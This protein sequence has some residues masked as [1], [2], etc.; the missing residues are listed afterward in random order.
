MHQRPM[1]TLIPTTSHPKMVSSLLKTA[2]FGMFDL[3][4]QPAMCQTQ[5]LFTMQW[6]PRNVFWLWR[7]VALLSVFVQ[8][9]PL[10]N[11]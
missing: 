8:H 9:K 4:T 1:A 5:R 3:D 10:I 7:L 6:G 2:H 11:H